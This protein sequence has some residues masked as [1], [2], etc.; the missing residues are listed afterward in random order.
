M[1]VCGGTLLKIV[2][3]EG[4]SERLEHHEFTG[5]LDK[6]CASMGRVADWPDRYRAD[7][8]YGCDW[9]H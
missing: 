7:Y 5:E 6:L 3:K 1:L 9:R 4:Y 8:R 2:G